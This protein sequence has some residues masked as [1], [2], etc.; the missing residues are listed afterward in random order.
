MAAKKRK[1]VCYRKLEKPYTRYSKFRSKSFVRARPVCRTVRFDM[2]ADDK[3]YFWQVDLLAKSDL[4]IRDRALESGR[5]ACNR[6]MEAK[7]GKKEF[8]FKV[9]VYPHHILR[10]NP[11][12]SGA[13]ADRMSTGMKHSFGKPIGLAARVKKKQSVFRLLVQEKHL[14]IARMA[15]KKAGHKIPC[16]VSIVAKKIEKKEAKKV[17]KEAVKE[18]K[19]ESPKEESVK[20]ETEQ[21]EPSVETSEAPAQA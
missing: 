1:F 11:L 6:T 20:Q 18:E 19:K 3:D 7:V 14:E 2:G 16:S 4:Q 8:K 13:G 10:E 9:M 21:P 12:A 15:I 17:K 5:Q